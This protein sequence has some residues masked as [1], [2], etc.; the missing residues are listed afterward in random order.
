MKRVAAR[1][2]LLILRNPV[3]VSPISGKTAEPL[4]AIGEAVPPTAILVIV[5]QLVLRL[6]PRVDDIPDLSN[7]RHAPPL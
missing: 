6:L 3:Q 5:E 2:N 4:R 1:R 7:V